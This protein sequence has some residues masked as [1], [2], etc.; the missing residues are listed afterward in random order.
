MKVWNFI[1]FFSIVIVI[2]T[3]IN[4]YIFI[5]ALHAFPFDG[6]WRFVFKIGF[7]A[8][9]YSYL[10]GRILERVWLSF[11]SDVLIWIG[12]FWLAAMLYLFLIVLFSDLIRIFGVF[13]PIHSIKF[14]LF[15]MKGFG[16]YSASLVTFIIIV[17]GFFNALFPRVKQLEIDIPKKSHFSTL[18]LV[19]ASDIHLGTIIGRAR[20]S[21]IAAR[22]NSLH[23]DLILLAG[24]VVDEDLAPVIRE[25]LGDDLKKLKAKYGVFAITGNHEYIGGADRAVAYLRNNGIRVLRDEIVLIENDFYLI[26]RDDR[27]ANRFQGRKRKSLSL[28][29]SGIDRTKPLIL[30][31]HQP[32]GLD[33]AVQN[34]IDL[35]ISG[36]THHGQ[37]FPLNFITN[38]VY[39]KSW[40]Y[41]KKG[42][43]HFYVSSGVGTWGPPIRLGNY[44]EIVRIRIKFLGNEH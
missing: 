43:T 23:P 25:N 39:E 6:K 38:M 17:I 22:I 40:G 12:S 3:A 34:E 16:F 41:L 33:E 1:I 28:L 5:R 35:Q 2:Y 24:D 13:F 26:G 8:V 30:M 11:L 44:P 20:F 19:V 36:H 18:N 15:R 10:L 14:S 7:W 42:K 9:V 32:F 31:D 37:L 4:L 29:V 27:S 21:R